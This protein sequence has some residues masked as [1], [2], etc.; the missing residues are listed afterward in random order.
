MVSE[1]QTG[2]THNYATK[3]ARDFLD[4]H[5]RVLWDGYGTMPASVDTTAAEISLDDLYEGCCIRIATKNVEDHCVLSVL[6]IEGYQWTGHGQGHYRCESVCP[7][8]NYVDDLRNTI[9]RACFNYE[10]AVRFE[11]TFVAT[12]SIDERDYAVL[13][14]YLSGKE[15]QTE[16]KSLVAVY[17]DGMRMEIRCVPTAGRPYVEAALYIDEDVIT[18]EPDNKIKKDWKCVYNGVTYITHIQ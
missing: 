11:R 3:L 6:F 14:S 10:K 9:L 8:Y 15:H 18:S 4:S 1:Q 17:D 2:M 5:N 13:R 12:I 16:T 7:T